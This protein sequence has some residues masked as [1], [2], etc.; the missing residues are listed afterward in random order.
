MTRT[1]LNRTLFSAWRRL[2]PHG[3]AVVGVAMACTRVADHSN[4]K[5]SDGEATSTNQAPT[6][7]QTSPAATT[8]LSTSSL[9]SSVTSESSSVA[10]E[11]KGTTSEES[12][13][14]S[15]TASSASGSTSTSKDTSTTSEPGPETECQPGET[16]ACGQNEVGD[17]IV[18]PGGVPQGSCKFGLQQCDGGLW[19]TC[20]G[21]IG[22]KAK[23]SCETGN[24]DNCNGVA[25]DH[26]DCEAG[27]TEP[28]GSAVGECR[29]GTRTCSPKGQ[30]GECEGQI[31]PTLEVCGGG[32]DEDCDGATD[33]QDSEC[34]CL[35]GSNPQTC[36]LPGQ[37]DCK[38]GKRSCEA[39]K[40]GACRPRFARLT[41]ERCGARS[42]LF[43][44]S[45]GDENCN[46]KIDELVP[47]EPSGCKFYMV[48]QDQDGQGALGDSANAPGNKEVTFGCF[49][50]QPAGTGWKRTDNRDAANLDC[51]DCDS[52]VKD[53]QTDFFDSASTCLK[54]IYWKG[55]AF[56]YN[57][58]SAEEVEHR[59]KLYCDF[60]DDECTRIRGFWSVLG[61]PPGCGETG[62]EG[63]CTENGPDVCTYLSL[64]DVTQGCH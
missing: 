61:D 23:D 20:K 64:R 5:K 27:S 56:D 36:D 44:K 47:T 58:T 45:T 22:P 26:C 21:A 55:G 8:G 15:P 14:E 10:E 9:T 46:G 62:M 12:P 51:G 31:K 49:C 40:W 6:T 17:N 19:G 1:A 50:E 43:G 16:R 25:T 42:D 60:V 38:L 39:G 4:S 54:Q 52:D 35:I 11:S 57:C 32:K 2:K 48:D 13:S 59:G 33:L 41:V 63:N 34:E 29:K 3:L 28:C 53:G 37:G 18:Y 24:D 7:S 30:W